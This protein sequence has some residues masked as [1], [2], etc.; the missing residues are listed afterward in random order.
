MENRLSFL[1]LCPKVSIRRVPLG[2]WLEQFLP[3]FFQRFASS[4][5][6]KDFHSS[7]HK[8][9]GDNEILDQLVQKFHVFHGI[10]TLPHFNHIWVYFGCNLKTISVSISVCDII[11]RKESVCCNTIGSI[12]KI[13]KPHKHQGQRTNEF[14]TDLKIQLFGFAE[15]HSHVL[16][17]LKKS[18]ETKKPGN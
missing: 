2:C 6:L 17:T 13:K 4:E 8:D 7:D 3:H 18:V 12:K 10:S 11:F 16:G 1:W 9:E 14:Q 5:V 15:F